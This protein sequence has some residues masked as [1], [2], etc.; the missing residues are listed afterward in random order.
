MKGASQTLH[1]H[2]HYFRIRLIGSKISH[3]RHLWRIRRIHLFPRDF[4]SYQRKRDPSSGTNIV[5]ENIVFMEIGERTT[6]RR[7]PREWN[8]GLTDI[9]T[10]WKIIVMVC[11]I[12]ALYGM[13]NNFWT[14]SY[15]S[16]GVTGIKISLQIHDIGNNKN[17]DNVG[18]HPWGRK[19][20]ESEL[21]CTQ[22]KERKQEDNAFLMHLLPLKAHS[23]S[24]LIKN[25]RD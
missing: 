21:F 11:F 7:W 22:Q 17:D 6:Y 24:V 3:S 5:W 9:D 10:H 19:S 14:N 18:C 1:F 8:L 23:V 4:D 20:R 25:Y 12:I 13:E 15:T 16:W 2:H